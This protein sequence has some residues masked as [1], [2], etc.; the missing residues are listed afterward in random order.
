MG[1]GDNKIGE[2]TMLGLWKKGRGAQAE[3]RADEASASVAKA[4]VTLHEIAPIRGCPQSV[5]GTGA[6]NVEVLGTGF[7]RG[8]R[9]RSQWG[10]K[11][12]GDRRRT[13]LKPTPP[14]RETE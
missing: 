5:T 12:S 7:R 3:C 14:N 1:M 8:R 9:L 13:S 6:T 4:Q 2:L 11:D 10:Q